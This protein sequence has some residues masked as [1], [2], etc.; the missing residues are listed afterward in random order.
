MR[1]MMREKLFALGN[2][3]IVQ[4]A[5]GRDRFTVDW[6]VFS[7]GQKLIF[8]DLIGNEVAS[9]HQ[10]LFGLMPTYEITRGD[11]ELTEVRK[12]VLSF[13]HERFTVDIPGPD[14]LEAT[15]SLLEHEYAF[16]RRGQTVARVSKASVALRDTF[17]VDIE[18]D[19]EDALFLAST[20]VFDMVSVDQQNRER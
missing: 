2:T 8:A 4:D 13:L 18:P 7:L 15:G 12:S 6:K 17:G 10:N 9:I 20:V 16:T 5:Q 11:T 3:F 1:Y 19:E 14:D